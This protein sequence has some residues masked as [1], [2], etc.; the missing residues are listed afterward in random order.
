MQTK[1]KK[2]LPTID[3]QNIRIA[4]CAA[5]FNETITEKLA[6]DAH[7]TL[8]EYGLQEKNIGVFW[9]PGA[10][11]IPLTCKLLA[12]TKKWD[13]IISIGAVIR[14]DTPHFEYVSSEVATGC[15]KVSYDLNIPVIF[16]VL[17]TNTY[18]EA[19]KRTFGSLAYK[20][21]E[22]AQNALEMIKLLQKIALS[23]P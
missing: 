17:T 5:R 16:G 9:V 8:L 4:I 11:E 10:F 21:K 19:E 2:F 15:A 23:R 14:G 7:E 13:A 18:E 12:E 20:G 22:A 6:K 1:P 3:T